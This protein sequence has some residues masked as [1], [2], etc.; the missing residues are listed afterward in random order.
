MNKE[1]EESLDSGW[2][3]RTACDHVNPTFENPRINQETQTTI[4]GSL[5]VKDTGAQ[6]SSPSESS[7]SASSDSND[8]IEGTENIT[9]AKQYLN[10]HSLSSEDLYT[11]LA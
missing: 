1:P 10:R 4:Q 3:Y 11:A 6:Y 9:V 8:N 5:K 2:R 7:D